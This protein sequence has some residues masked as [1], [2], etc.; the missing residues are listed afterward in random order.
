VIGI[1]LLYPHG[2]DNDPCR[3]YECYDREFLH[4]FNLGLARDNVF[5]AAQGVR[6]ETGLLPSMKRVSLALEDVL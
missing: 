1:V 4:I 3:K 5:G 2:F 6:Y